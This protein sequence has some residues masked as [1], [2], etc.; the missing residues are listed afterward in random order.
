MLRK[1]LV[2][3]FVLGVVAAAASTPTDL[4]VKTAL[5]KDL[6]KYPN[7]QVQVDDRLVR[8]TGTVP[9]YLD[10][11]SITRKA[12]SYGAVTNVLNVV[13]V[14][15]ATVSDQDLAGKLARK[16]AY[17]RSGQGNVFNWFTVAVENGKV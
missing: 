8:I 13:A 4:A 7:V 5:A 9:T 15:A 17:D 14:D 10:K 2:Y 1:A 3:V 16:L 12:K 6:S 11:Q